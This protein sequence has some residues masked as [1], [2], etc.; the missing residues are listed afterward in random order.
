[1]EEVIELRKAAPAPPIILIDPG[2]SRL[3]Y[4]QLIQVYR[5]NIIRVAK[6]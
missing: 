4:S 2:L 1:M 3:S 6:S 5:P